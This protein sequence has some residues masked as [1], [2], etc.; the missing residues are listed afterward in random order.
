MM[1]KQRY[2][3][4]AI[5]SF[6]ILFVKAQDSQYSM[7]DASSL[8]LN[9]ANAGTDEDSKLRAVSQYRTQWASL[10]SNF[11]TSS[12]AVDMPFKD[13]W[14]LGA[15]LFHNDASNIMKETGVIFSGSYD[16]MSPD[17]DVHH[18]T[19]GL[20][21]GFINKNVNDKE[22]FFDNQYFD[23]TFNTNIESGESFDR[24][25][26]FM[27]EVTFGVAYKNNDKN[28]AYR[29]YGGF[30]LFHINKPDESYINSFN[31]R[32]PLRWVLNGGM[33]L[34]FQNEEIEIDPKFLLMKQS[35]NWNV[36]LGVTGG[37]QIGKDIKVL[38]GGT[39]RLG[40]AIIPQ[41]G[42]EY[43]NFTYAMSYD[44]NISQLKEFS[45]RRGALEFVVIYKGIGGFN[46]QSTGVPRM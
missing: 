33:K 5:F 7:Y 8:M 37:Y 3:L 35:N 23:G 36:I 44:I 14:G 21:L 45:N 17:Q 28:K 12:L 29:P 30:S 31:S 16:V 32:V 43:L 4:I 34:F 13:R 15:Y 10:S 11:I 22:L 38:G 27:P 1:M 40:D 24:T 19:T 2:V 42:V 41:L 26:R 46:M 25:N 39:F 9:P 20:N 6:S 18:L